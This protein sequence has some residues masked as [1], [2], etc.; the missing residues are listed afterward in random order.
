MPFIQYREFCMKNTQ[1]G[2]RKYS[3]RSV[4]FNFPTGHRGENR[5][6]P[7]TPRWHSTVVFSTVE[8]QWSVGCRWRNCGVSVEK[9]WRAGG[10][11][12]SCRWSGDSEVQV[13]CRWRKS[14]DEF[15]IKK[16]SFRLRFKNVLLIRKHTNSDINNNVKWLKI[17]ILRWQWP[18]K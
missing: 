12:I 16:T 7:L 8:P 6:V 4:D 14:N 11:I 17:I 15:L 9:L 18:T 13:A 10:E 3:T 5:N 1:F 2:P